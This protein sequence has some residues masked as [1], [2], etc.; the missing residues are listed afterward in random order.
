MST[1]SIST[2]CPNVFA[3]AQKDGKTAS[4][5]GIQV[6]KLYMAYSHE[7][8]AFLMANSRSPELVEVIM[9]DIYLKLMAIPDLSVIENPSAYLNRL[10]N[11]LLIDHYRRQERYQ[12]R[13]LEQPIEELSLVESGPSLNE[14]LHYDQLLQAYQQALSELPDSMQQVVKLYHV[15]GL[16]HREIARKL[17]KSLSWVEKSITKAI[18]HC[19]QQL[20]DFDY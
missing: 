9:Q 6:E 15:D 11:N 3:L 13:M 8:K 2:Q 19:R 1:G 5:D 12:K 7:L 16:T 18:L 20:N 10:A 17:G 14:Q 4:V